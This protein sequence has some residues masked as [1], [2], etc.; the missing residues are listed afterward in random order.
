MVSGFACVS[1]KGVRCGKIVLG[2]RIRG[3]EK[4]VVGGDVYAPT[5]NLFARA[6]HGKQPTVEGISRNRAVTAVEQRVVEGII[7]E[8]RELLCEW[9]CVAV[10]DDGRRGAEVRSEYERVSGGGVDSM[11][12]HEQQSVA[13]LSV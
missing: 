12:P 13:S 8:L 4:K 5:T 3:F 6:R 9:L 2:V 10:F 1:D 7:D 11:R